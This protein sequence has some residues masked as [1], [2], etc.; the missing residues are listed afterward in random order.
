[1]YVY[2][3][4]CVRVY[5]CVCVCVCV[6]TRARV[7]VCMRPLLKY[8]CTNWYVQVHM[9]TSLCVHVRVC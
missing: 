9:Y 7:C 3:L 5:V 8:T 4:D 6:C 1:M 2:L